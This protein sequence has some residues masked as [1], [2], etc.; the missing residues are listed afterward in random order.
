LSGRERVGIDS[1]RGRSD[2]WSR[3]ARSWQL[4]QLRGRGSIVAGRTKLGFLL[5]VA[6]R[7]V[8]CVIA[9]S[10]ADRSDARD[11]IQSRGELPDRPRAADFYQERYNPLP[12]QLVQRRLVD[13][14]GMILP[15]CAAALA[16]LGARLTLVANGLPST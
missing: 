6:R 16:C 12:R 7:L 13:F 1:N 11:L 4:K 15:A 5:F 14:F 3:P 10:D 9:I 2:A 8:R